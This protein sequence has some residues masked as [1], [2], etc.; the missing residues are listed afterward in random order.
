[1]TLREVRRVAVAF[2]PLIP[3]DA[4]RFS[5]SADPLVARCEF[6]WIAALRMAAR[7]MLAAQ[8]DLPLDR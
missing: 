1:V 4:A 6:G 5:V 2:Q 7:S 8:L 3:N